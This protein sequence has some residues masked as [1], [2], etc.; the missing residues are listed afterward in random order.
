VS[1]RELE[2]MEQERLEKLEKLNKDIQEAELK[3]Q[4]L[5]KEKSDVEE[6]ADRLRGSI[7]EISEQI[8]TRNQF[9]NKT[10]RYKNLDEEENNKTLKIEERS[11]EIENLSYV[12]RFE[13]ELDDFLELQQ[14]KESRISE[15]QTEIKNQ[16][17]LLEEKKS[18]LQKLEAEEQE[19]IVKIKIYLKR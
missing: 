15:I 5:K 19:R 7:S 8:K 17:L 3:F 4:Y 16:E 12:F 11:R 2:L 6:E 1:F 9:L 10:C 14:E 18:N 13:K